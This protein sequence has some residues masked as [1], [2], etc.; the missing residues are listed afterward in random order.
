MQK[1]LIQ[2]EMEYLFCCCTSFPNPQADLQVVMPPL[3]PTPVHQAHT[4]ASHPAANC[5]T[6]STNQATTT[7]AVSLSKAL[8]PPTPAS[9]SVPSPAPGH[10]LAMG[11]VT[12]STHPA[13]AQGDQPIHRINFHAPPAGPD[14]VPPP[15][16]YARKATPAE[17]AAAAALI[18]KAPV[19]TPAPVSALLSSL[20]STSP[21][22]I[23]AV[24]IHQVGTPIPAE[25]AGD[26]PAPL[27]CAPSVEH[28]GAEALVDCAASSASS[29]GPSA[30]A[31]GTVPKVCFLHICCCCMRMVMKQ[32]FSKCCICMQLCYAV[33][34]T[35]AVPAMKPGMSSVAFY[36]LL[37]HSHFR[38]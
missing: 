17:L 9:S 20:D 24:S 38:D 15:P 31:H 14:V 16:E 4:P 33:H 28:G 3:V 34:T 23:A 8:P 32:V 30:E 1:I 37:G 22:D 35:L 12:S 2:Q 26:S 11:T 13:V 6:I 19:L 25:S 7:P 27:R 36:V 21:A 5:T 18:F 29:L 10:M